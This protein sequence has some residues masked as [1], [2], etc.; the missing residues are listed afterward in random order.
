M[1]EGDENAVSL[2]RVT[3]R[4]R[5]FVLDAIDLDIPMGRIVGLVGANGSGKSTLFRI[6]MGLVRAD[7][8]TVR[9]LG[10]RLPDEQVPVKRRIG[11]VSEDMT[12]HPEGSLDWHCRVVRSLNPDWDEKRSSALMEGFHLRGG[13]KAKELSRG[14]ALKAMLVLALGH[15]PRLLLLDE[16]TAGLDPRSRREVLAELRRLAR[17]EG[18]A[19]VMSSHLP[20]DIQACAHAT[21]ELEAGR[22]VAGAATRRAVEVP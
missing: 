9:V 4:Y 18:C 3:K 12:L 8:G 15:R 5:H 22:I 21:I 17:D 2:R 16:A 1:L 10:G 7:S 13:R 6:M 11:F 14:E 20:D 19:V